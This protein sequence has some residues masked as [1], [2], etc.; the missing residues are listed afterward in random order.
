MEVKMTT[1]KEKQKIIK[2]I[3]KIADVRARARHMES[4]FAQ[5]FEKVYGYEF[6][7]NKHDFLVDV[8]QG[9]EGYITLE[10]FEDN[11]EFSK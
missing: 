7:F 11:L 1:N 10:E 2:I 3:N 5:L 4:Y 9:G 6:D 8:I